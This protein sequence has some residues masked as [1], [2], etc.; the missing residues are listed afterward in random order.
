MSADTLPTVTAP[1]GTACRSCGGRTI[2]WGKD[3]AGN[4]RRRCKVCKAT[5]GI[6]PPRPLGSM[7]LDMDK[8]VLV[9]SLLTEGSSIRSTERVSGVH[10]DTVM[11][12]LRLAGAK[13]ET[14]LSR[15]VRNVEVKDVQADE[16]WSFVG[17]KEKT[18]QRLGKTDAE[19]GDAYT[20]VGIERDSKLALAFHMGCRTSE[21]TSLFMAKLSGATAGRFQLTTDGFGAY[22]AA[23]EQHFG[24]RVDFGQLI[25]TYSAETVDSERRYSPARIISAEKI[26]V[27]GSPAE[28]KICTS[29]VERTNLHIRMQMRR[30]TRLT[31]AFSR[32]RSNLNAALALHFAA[33]NF[34]WMHKSIRMTP[35]MKAGIARKPWTVRDLL[36]A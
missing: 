21:D 7:R 19:L 8:A 10:R 31:N 20:F 2:G 24:G 27:S 9:L 34:T 6:I 30:F 17:M 5:F 16:L 18:K 26:A 33:Y 3:R 11:R 28:E 29:H 12:L 15:L 14:L 4:P 23:V 36:I 22:P 25:K 13:C 32:K 1:E 35:A